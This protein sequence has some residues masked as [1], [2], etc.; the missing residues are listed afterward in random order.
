VFQLKNWLIGNNGICEDCDEFFKSDSLYRLGDMKVLSISPKYWKYGL[1]VELDSRPGG[2]RMSFLFMNNE[3]SSMGLSSDSSLW[4]EGLLLVEDLVDMRSMFRLFLESTG[5]SF[6]SRATISNFWK[7]SSLFFTG[8]F[9]SFFLLGV[10]VS[11]LANVG[12]ESFIPGS[13]LVFRV[14]ERAEERILTVGSL[15]L[16]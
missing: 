3:K 1:W 5:D 4:D 2:V 14:K 9:F 7:N 11:T 10:Y 13:L 16:E 6:R 8:S 15:A 12:Q